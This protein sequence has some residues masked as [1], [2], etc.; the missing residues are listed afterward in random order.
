VA[1]PQVPWRF[2]QVLEGDELVTERRDT[3]RERSVGGFQLPDQRIPALGSDRLG[4]PRVHRRG[5]EMG[6]RLD[7]G[8][9]PANL[10]RVEPTI[11]ELE[12][13]PFV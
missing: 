7:R 9:E 5:T 13:D 8:D 11:G 3:A 6:D 1:G 10:S 12:V 2:E 4:V